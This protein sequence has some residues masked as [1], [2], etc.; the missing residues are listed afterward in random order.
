MVS[1]GK[2]AVKVKLDKS[3]GEGWGRD[4]MS[5]KRICADREGFVV[6]SASFCPPAL[7]SLQQLSPDQGRLAS[8]PPQ[9]GAPCDS[10]ARGC[11]AGSWEGGGGE[12]TAIC[13]SSHCDSGYFEAVCVG[14]RERKKGREFYWVCLALRALRDCCAVS[15][16]LSLCNMFPVWGEA[17]QC[18]YC[19]FSSH[20]LTEASG[21]TRR[22][23]WFSLSAFV[24]A[25]KTVTFCSVRCKLTNLA[26]ALV[27][28]P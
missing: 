9:P 2:E 18:A 6:C 1:R 26:T 13:C 12:L 27:F 4:S 14:G 11:G 7:A 3:D 20:W 23:L 15:S 25:V 21:G 8:K 28:A 22:H 24:H 17:A 5:R 19:F 16:S 10:W